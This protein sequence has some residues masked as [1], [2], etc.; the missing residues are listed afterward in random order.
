MNR[1]LRSNIK[2]IGGHELRITVTEEAYDL[3]LK[4]YNGVFDCLRYQDSQYNSL[5]EYKKA[6]PE[7]SEEDCDTF[8]DRNMRGTLRFA[9]ELL[10]KGILEAEG[11]IDARDLTLVPTELF[12]DFSPDCQ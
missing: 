1:T 5:N 12:K 10:Q 4:L 3:F 6:H 9:K 8:L 2:L 11:D 7:L